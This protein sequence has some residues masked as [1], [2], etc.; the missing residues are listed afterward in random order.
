[1]NSA[2]IS[3]KLQKYYVKKYFFFKAGSLKKLKFTQKYIINF[4]VTLWLSKI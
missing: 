4:I 3:E 2:F 1:M